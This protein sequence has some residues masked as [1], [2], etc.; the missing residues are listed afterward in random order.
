MPVRELLDHMPKKIVARLMP[1][2]DK[3]AQLRRFGW[4]GR[5]LFASDLWHLNRRT[6]ALAFL[7]GIF[8][9]C[10]PMPMQMLAAAFTA[11]II[12]CNVPISIG[13]VFLTNPVTMPPYYLAAY[14]LGAWILQS[15]PIAL[16]DHFTLGWLH[17]QLNLVWLPLLV[18]C[19]SFGVILGIVSYFGVRIWWAI[20]VR[21]MWQ[22]RQ[23]RIKLNSAARAA[24][25]TADLP[26]PPH[27]DRASQSID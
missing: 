27:G 2:P 5:K 12:R 9:A 6:V 24:A 26:L 1:H 20:Q 16:P 11:L 18:G 7:N 13:L 22:V 4:L 3:L 23:K 17:Q 19:L 25:A 10:M 14:Q 15:A 8:W 21:V